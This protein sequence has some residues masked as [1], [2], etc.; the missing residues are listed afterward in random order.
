MNLMS[1]T[2]DRNIER[3]IHLMQTDE[4]FDAP[5]DAIQWSKNI[6]RTRAAALAPQKS[7]G[8]RILAVLQIDLS[9]NR[10]AFGER[11]ASGA[12]ARQMLFQAGSASIDLR[13][14][15]AAKRLGL[16]G[17][18]LGEDFAG[19]L[20]RIHNETGSYEARTNELS[21]FEFSGIARGTYNLSLQSDE[22]EIVVANLDL[23]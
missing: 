21:E 7:F 3:I 12:Q 5:Q 23:N 19:C 13:I 14:K 22:K 16:H 15:S 6:F 1:K 8:E 18:I 11:S 2:P 17:Q 20:V 9:P 4:S 10:A